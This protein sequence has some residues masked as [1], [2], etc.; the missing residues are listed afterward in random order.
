[1]KTPR[2]HPQVIQSDEHASGGARRCRCCGGTRI[3][4]DIAAAALRCEECRNLVEV[5]T[6]HSVLK[7]NDPVSELRGDVFG[8][9]SHDIEPD[10]AVIRTLKCQTCGAE[11]LIN[12][13]RGLRARCHWCRH[14]LSQNQQV[15]SG[16]VPDMILPF[17]ITKEHASEILAGFVGGR[18]W[19][20]HRKFLR[21][22]EPANIMG[23]YLPYAVV[24]IYATMRIGTAPVFKNFVVEIDDLV[25]P[26][27]QKWEP[28][29][30][31]KNRTRALAGLGPFDI[32][33]AVLFDANHLADFTAQQ[34]DLN[35][36]VLGPRVVAMASRRAA[37]RFASTLQMR[38][39]PRPKRF[40][41]IG[42]RWMTAYLPAWVY[43]IT[44]QR[45]GRPQTRY[46]I[47][48]GR[49]GILAGVMPRSTLR[50][51]AVAIVVGA[52]FALVGVGIA[53]IAQG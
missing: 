47:V 53:L 13:A 20:A 25:Y 40:D 33:N 43:S 45:F 24:D 4:L 23:V 3:G 52:I 12:T 46:L 30:R 29:R 17:A 5:P 10:S 27:A 49:S 2:R 21:E 15:P 18:R 41:V 38:N 14:T 39:T 36:A 8:S 42:R 7:I 50:S 1:M 32:E 34:R 37:Q 9:G 19:L 6:A 51:A 48:N 35:V 26:A 11:V 16:A 31:E 28:S 22:F 44:I